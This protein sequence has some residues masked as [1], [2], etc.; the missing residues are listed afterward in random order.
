MAKRNIIRID[1]A[2]CD[3]CGLCVTSC[4]EGAIQIVD[5]KAK[6][7]SE[8][9][10]DGL[11][12]CLAECPQDALSIE[13]RDADEFDESAV[14]KHLENIKKKETPACPSTA[15]HFG[16]CPG[17]MARTLE[18]KAQAASGK[19]TPSQLRNWPVQLSLVPIKAPYFSGA[20]LLIAADCVPFAF[21]DFHEKYLDGR[22]LLI[23]CPKLDDSSAY[24]DKLTQ[25]FL[26]NDFESIEV[27]HMEVPCCTGLVRVVSAALANS[28][29]KI[30]A[31]TVVVSIG[32]SILGGNDL[33][34]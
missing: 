30:P 33:E 21:A 3:G 15:P 13:E 26:Q 1:E 17:S 18:P 9:Y 6:L 27:L 19:E 22:I 32:G 7:V 4:A 12:A 25:I 16:G 2:K 34:Y 31:K 10:C 11:G 24:L 5:G 28:G 29:K 14:E 20:K 23:G 8:T